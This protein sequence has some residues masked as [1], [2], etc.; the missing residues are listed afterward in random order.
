MSDQ[1]KKLLAMIQIKLEVTFPQNRSFINDLNKILQDLMEATYNEGF[2]DGR[3]EIA[4]ECLAKMESMH[5]KLKSANEALIKLRD[6][7]LDDHHRI[8]NWA[9]MRS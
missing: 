9:K 1:L 5:G 4:K 8:L 7:T 6:S 2:A 3:A